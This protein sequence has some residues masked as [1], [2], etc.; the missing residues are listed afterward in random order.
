MIITFN[1]LA[2]MHLFDIIQS[3]ECHTM[4]N[5]YYCIQIGIFI[6]YTSHPSSHMFQ[7]FPGLCFANRVHPL[8]CSKLLC[9]PN[10]ISCIR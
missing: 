3:T 2:R 5:K 7:C 9:R 4:P 10:R 6:C 8:V 1:D